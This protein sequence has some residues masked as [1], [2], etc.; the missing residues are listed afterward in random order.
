MDASAIPPLAYRV[1][2]LIGRPATDSADFRARLLSTKVV[3]MS[4]MQQYRN[5]ADLSQFY[6]SKI[7]S[8]IKLFQSKTSLKT[9]KHLKNKW[10]S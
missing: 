10:S 4:L 1:W 3:Q 8:Q 7:G 6:V 5:I 2:N 9:N